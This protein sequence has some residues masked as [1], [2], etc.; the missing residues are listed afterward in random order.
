MKLKKEDIQSNI[1]VN[2]DLE[3]SVPYTYF[4]RK[5]GNKVY[6]CSKI[7]NDKWREDL[8]PFN[9]IPF[10]EYKGEL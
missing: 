10:I 5:I 1:D 3:N 7:G 6:R 8:M 9:E 4:F 2:I